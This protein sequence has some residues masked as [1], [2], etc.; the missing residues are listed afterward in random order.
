MKLNKTMIRNW[1]PV[2]DY[3]RGK[4]YFA[5][6]CVRQFTARINE[7]SASAHCVVEGTQDYDV[8][9]RIDHSM[10]MGQCTC[11]RFADRGYCKHIAAALL[12]LEDQI[13]KETL[14]KTTDRY[15]SR[16]I[17]LYRQKVERPMVSYTGTARL[18]PSVEP[19]IGLDYPELS[20]QVGYDR[21]YVVKDVK[22]FLGWVDTGEELVYGKH[23]TLNHALP[24]FTPWSQQL[25]RLLMEQYRKYRS[26][27]TRQNSYYSYYNRYNQ[28]SSS[29]R[30]VRLDGKS[31]DR[32][33]ALMQ[34]RPEEEAPKKG[35]LLFGD[36]DPEFHASFQRL[37]HSAV[38]RL[39]SR[40]LWRFFGS[41]NQLYATDD[42][43]IL[44]CSADFQ[45]RVYPM[46][47]V[48]SR[49]MYFALSDLSTFCSVVLPDL[50]GMVE[51]AD[52]DGLLEQ[53]L[54]DEMTPRFYLDLNEDDE[55]VTQLRFLY[56]ETELPDK[57]S[58]QPEAV[59]RDPRAEQQARN[60]LLQWFRERSEQNHYFLFGEE[61]IFDFL[62]EELSTLQESGE[63]FL[64]D[65]VKN[66]QLRPTKAT[67]GISVA[68]GMLSLEFDTGDFPAEELKALYNSLLR[69][70]RYHKLKN[71]QFLPLNGSAVEKLAEAVHMTQLSAKDL[72]GGK[73]TLPLYRGLY[74]DS[75]LNG[76]EGVEVS[77][78]QRFRSMV[79]SFKTV[80]ESDYQ[81]PD[82][83]RGV[84]RPYQK[85]GFRWLKTLESCGFGGILAD[86]MGLGKT[87]QVIA[88]LSTVRRE[89]GKKT[90]L[91]VCPA[92]LILNWGD[93]FARFAPEVAVTLVMGTVKERRELMARGLAES[94]VLV[95]SYDLLKRD[96]AHYREREFYCCVLDEGQFV[97]NQSTL[98]SKAVKSIPCA[99]RFVLTGTPI[100]NRLSELW[101]LYDFLMPGYL[102]THN[103]FV[104]KLEKPIVKSEDREAREQ[105]RRLVRP[106]LLRRLKADVL[107]ELPPKV[108]HIR[109]VSM[110]DEERKT[111]AA[112]VIAAREGLDAGGSKLQI[113]A[114]LT[115]LRQICC[116][117]GLCYENYSGG[118]SKL[119]AC[120]EL[121]VGMAENGHQILL[122]SQFTTMLERIRDRLEAAKLTCFTLQGSTPKEQRARLVRDFNAGKAQVF[123]ISLKAGGTGLNL[124]AADVVIHYDPWWN[125]A[126]QNQATDRAHRMG[127]RESVQVYKLIVKDSI[128]EKILDLQA[129]KA[130]LM[131]AVAD[132]SEEGI[133]TMSK[134]ELLALLE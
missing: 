78:D 69:R 105:L 121:C 130:E 96:I 117:A 2:P 114:A 41:D 46:L 75:V 95:T 85:T 63:V 112:S 109:R 124:T 22:E 20:F 55:L 133:L 50:Q 99:Q 93:E 39:E 28:R 74:L 44:R 10:M 18:V 66:R 3:N 86:E 38:L 72:K 27:S 67:V 45:E 31:F 128:E 47:Q 51:I 35:N 61:H 119:D 89:A 68:D 29:S 11:L 76:Q 5:E 97:K 49:E 83:L 126:A 134:E 113:L 132:G 58:G 52:P 122:F 23:L 104:E 110:E 1:V 123:L 73:V 26:L 59:R 34:E 17:E 118:T 7:D 12:R 13:K 116:D 98:A 30:T 65:R 87:I 90:S 33:F 88:F 79:R 24:E 107:K 21:L 102:F 129:K 125:L 25:I 37:S 53:Y 106:F 101:N 131:D 14:E 115:R 80:S 48:G 8:S 9:L 108:E 120:V 40:G 16:V 4:Q 42:R 84:L 56:G 32:F 70:R 82:G 62:T 77:R 127:Q 57:A 94:D 103:R 92:S 100:E 64:S 54:P 81:V 6:G 43:S 91:I 15:A 71:G 36:G 111:Y 60:L 19:G